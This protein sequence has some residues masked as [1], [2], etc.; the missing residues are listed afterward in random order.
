MIIQNSL[1]V[2]R[3]KILM[4]HN[5]YFLALFITFYM[6]YLLRETLYAVSENEMGLSRQPI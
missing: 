5:Q 6:S 4:R 3:A 1:D 2:L